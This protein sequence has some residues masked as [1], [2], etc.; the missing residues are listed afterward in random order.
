MLAWMAFWFAGFLP[1]HQRG[2]IRMDPPTASASA[3]STLLAASPCGKACGMRPQS[4]ED[5]EGDGD[6]VRNCGICHLV[7]KL[8]VPQPFIIHLAPLASPD[9]P[10]AAVEAP[11]ASRLADPQFLGRAPPIIKR[12]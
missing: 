12:A 8:D 7:A 1:A 9:P 4:G 6:P 2:L 5:G 11:L 3:G 10:I